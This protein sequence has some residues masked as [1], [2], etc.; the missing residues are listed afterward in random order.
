ART[1]TG[2]PATGPATP[3]PGRTPTGAPATARTTTN[4]PATARTTTHTPAMGRAATHTPTMGRTTTGIGRKTPPLMP[5][6]AMPVGGRGKSVTSAPNFAAGTERAGKQADPA[7]LAEVQRLVD[8]RIAL[9][10]ERAD[11]YTMIGV[12]P[13]A[14]AEVIR[15]AYFALARQLHPDR[16]AA[17][18][19]ADDGQHAHK[20]VA[21]LN[22]AFTV[23]SDPKR[24]ADYDAQLDDGG[25]S[26]A[27]EEADQ[28]AEDMAIRILQAEEIF[29]RGEQALKRDD[30]NAAITEF[31]RAIDL[32]PDE[33]DFHA[34]HA[35][36]TFCASS[37]KSSVAHQT[38]VALERAIERSPKAINPRFYLGRVERML[39][40]DQAALVHFRDVLTAKPN[41]YEAQSE[42]RVI[43]ARLASGGSSKP[44][45]GLFGRKR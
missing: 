2:T 20:V 29:R 3:T 1:T 39:G 14:T 10:D 43:E 15:K 35:W 40:R 18:N 21:Q 34:M 23:L 19:I 44:G 8:E 38:R 36:A 42:V 5:P 28:R 17:L 31:K 24:R 30:L 33:A 22:T 6:T 13:G 12:S 26:A 7:Q 4:K 45:S 16:L 11:H 9:L 32:N 27:K 41:H 25:A 37:D